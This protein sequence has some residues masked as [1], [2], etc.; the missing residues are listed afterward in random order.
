MSSAT[1]CGLSGGSITRNIEVPPVPAF[2]ILP[3][4]SVFCSGQPLTLS[5]QQNSGEI[6]GVT[7]QQIA[8]GA[9]YTFTPTSDQTIGVQV[10]DRFGCTYPQSKK[11]VVSRV[12]AAIAAFENSGRSDDNIVCAGDAVRLTASGGT[13]YTWSTGATGSEIAV[14]PAASTRYRVFAVNNAGCRDTADIQIGLNPALVVSEV[15]RNTC[16][17]GSTGAIA[18]NTS[19]GTPGYRYRWSNGQSTEGIEN[20]SAGSYQVEV[21]DG[22]GCVLTR[23]FTISDNLPA[24]V[25]EVSVPQASCSGTPV[26]VGLQ[27]SESMSIRYRIGAGG[28]QTINA[29]GTTALNL[30][31]GALANSEQ[32]R[33]VS[34]ISFATGCGISGG[35]ITRNIEVLTVPAPSAD[36]ITVCSGASFGIPVRI[37]TGTRQVLLDWEASYGGL[38]GGTGSGAG[39]IAGTDAISDR[40]VNPT[41]SVIQAQYRISPYI[42]SDGQRCVGEPIEVAVRVQPEPTVQTVGTSEFCSGTPFSL[43]LA[44][45]LSGASISWSR[46]FAGEAISG[47]GNI[48]DLVDNRSN[49]VQE[50][51]YRVSAVLGECSGPVRTLSV[52]LRPVPQMVIT[53]PPKVCSGFADLTSAGITAGSGAGLQFSYW[54]DPNL[55]QALQDPQRAAAGVY[56]ISARDAGGCT[57][58]GLVRVQAAVGLRVNHPEPLCAGGLADL[59]KPEITKGSDANLFYTYW[60]DAAATKVLANPTGVPA[61]NY[62]IKAEAEGTGNCFATLPVE[63]QEAKPALLNEGAPLQVCSGAEFQFT[64]T[65]SPAGSIF[66]W[67]RESQPGV[68]NFYAQGTGEIRERLNLSGNSPVQ[69]RYQYRLSAPGCGNLG[70]KSGSIQVEVSPPPTFTVTDSVELCSPTQN[71]NLIVGPQPG[72]KFSFSTDSA[73]LQAINDPSRVL[74]GQYF[75]R[76]ENT[77]GCVAVR[78]TLVRSRIANGIGKGEIVVC[79]PLTANLVTYTNSTGLAAQYAVGFVRDLGAVQTVANPTQVG[80]GIYYLSLNEKTDNGSGCSALVPVEVVSGLAS[81]DSPQSIEEQ[82]SGT[83]FVYQPTSKSKGI[84]F[85]WQFLGYDSEVVGDSIAGTGP[86]SLALKNESGSLRTAKFRITA[87]GSACSTSTAAYLLGVGV[88]PELRLAKSDSLIQIK[89]GDSLVIGAVLAR[90]VPIARLN[91]TAA[92]GSI[93]GGKGKGAG[94]P[95]GPKAI[96]EQLFNFSDTTGEVTYRLVPVL[97]G[98]R[99][100]E[101]EPQIIRAAIRQE[102]AQA[103]AGIAGGI[104]TNIGIGIEGAELYLSGPTQS[105]QRTT[106]ARGVFSF[107]GIVPGYDYSLNPS[108]NRDPLNGVS[109]RDLI[110]LQFHLLGKKPIEDPYQLIAADVNNSKSITV[111]DVIAMR[112]L[113]LGLES[114]FPSNRSWRFVDRDY[115]F[116]N[117]RSPWTP[118]FPELKNY[119]DIFGD[120]TGDFIGVKIGDI[121]GDARANSSQ[122][123]APRSGETMVLTTENPEVRKG[124]RLVLPVRISGAEPWD[125]MQFTLGYDRRALRLVLS[126]CLFPKPENIGI[127]EESTLLTCSWENTLMPGETVMVLHFEVLRDGKPSDWVDL[128][129]RI[130]TAEGYLGEDTRPLD[131]R[132]VDA[133]TNGQ[134]P[135]AL[136]NYPNP[137]YGQTS[138]P[139]WLPSQDKVWIKVY[140]VNGKLV[141]E[142]EGVFGAGRNYFD[143]KIEQLGEGNSWYYQVGGATWVETRQMMRF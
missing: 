98:A 66:E 126:D 62:F 12:N 48:E 15:L 30:N 60:L 37:A 82:C 132:F 33:V 57:T 68:T 140:D 45:N 81:L 40:L 119:N 91:W 80:T 117:P 94:I 102:A 4:D 79:P 135:R 18:L 115:V 51:N 101:G 59:T 29:L 27:P 114:G 139:F 25:L 136:Q 6:T 93:Q 20:L 128:N 142:Q 5:V 14:S 111:A 77:F 7:W 13:A 113:I 92:Y 124:E 69:I 133:G 141:L 58:S 2:S 23:D 120:Q 54:R 28:E 118:S 3:L 103:P 123:L 100:C 65:S 87:R 137:F 75:I 67:R 116:P 22:Y 88:F 43:A 73:G 34:A 1:G 105:I 55:T 19:G 109:T 10:T 122:G 16:P 44:S 38:V 89:S 130:S 121:N 71:L 76:G 32:F 95:M 47:R 50:I 61:G 8:S 70:A 74:P 107:S 56:Y 39:I 41:V 36:F 97:S 53:A 131:L 84:L 112:K 134:R 42:L 104:Q 9:S 17:G 99:A 78:S 21:G 72:L 106:S 24:P 52:R 31:L 83:T 129:S 86:I 46:E 138:V 143:L 127:F 125:G 26:S 63:V 96:A 49:V 35:G 108:L 64:A 90:P 110:F 85:S 11:I